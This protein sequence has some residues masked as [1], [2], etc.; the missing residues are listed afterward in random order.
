MLLF[1]AFSCSGIDGSLLKI[2]QVHGADDA[3]TQVHYH[4]RA[5]DGSE[6]LA[7]SLTQGN[8]DTAIDSVSRETAVRL[9]IGVSNEG[10]VTSSSTALQ[11]QYGTKITSCSAVAAWV[12]VNAVNAAWEMYDS[13]H[14]TDGSNTTNISEAAGG[15]TDENT[16]FISA[17]A[18]LKDTS[19]LV[20]STTLASTEF[21]ETEFSIIQ[22]QQAAYGATYCFRLSASGSP[23]DAYSVYPE[24]TTA[25]ERDF[26]V[27][28][29]TVTVSGTSATITAGVDYIAPA[30]TSSAFIRI[31]NS[32]YT[33]AGK[34]VIGGTQPADDVTVAIADPENIAT[35]V[36]FTRA[37]TALNN[38]R[39]SWE[40]VEFVGIPGSDNEF[41]VRD[42]DVL[43]YGTT[44]LSA[45]GTAASVA[46]DNDVVVFIT[47]QRTPDT[48]TSD[49]NTGIS[50]AAWANATDEPV[51]TRGETGGDAAVVSY[52]VVEFTGAN[53]NIERVEH[54][55]AAA[56]VTETESITPVNSLVR[57]F[58]HTQKRSGTGLSGTDEYGHEVWLSSIGAVSFLLQNGA[59]NPGD[60]TSV[61]WVI[62]NTQTGLGSM[63]VT[64]SNG[65]TSGGDEPLTLSVSIG[66]TLTDIS[67]A[68]IFAN[69][70]GVGIGTTYPRPIAGFFIASS[71]HYEIWRSDTGTQMD[72]R[73]E[74]VEWPTAKLSL[75]QNDYRFYVDN[76]AIDPTDPWPEG[77]VDL[78][79]NTVLTETDEP[80]QNGERIRIRMSLTAETA[81]FPQYS[82]SFKLQYGERISTCG[83]ISEAN[84]T[85]V[86]AIGSGALW[87]GYNA[88]TTD[89]TVLSTEPPT[90]GDLNLTV[91][92]TAG[93]YEKENS[94]AINPY[95]VDMGDDVEFD[96]L[97]QQ[98]NAPSGTFYCFRMV[99]QNGTLLGEYTDYPQLR[100]ASFNPRSQHWRFY[101]DAENETP[102]LALASEVTAPIDVTRNDSLKLRVTVKEISNMPED[103]ARF[104]LQFSEDINFAT[105]T[106]VS[107]TSTCTN[108]SVWCYFD[109]AGVDNATITTAVLSDADSCSAGAGVGCGTHNESPL[110][111]SGFRHSNGAATE[112]EFSIIPKTVHVNTVYYFRLYD[113]NADLPVE[114]NSGESYPS[115]VTTGATLVFT[116]EGLPSG[117]T[118]DSY[119]TDA[120]TTP[121]SV[122]F[123]TVPFDTE[124]EAAHRLAVDTNATEGYQVL[125]YSDQQL[126]NAYGSQ[127]EP[128]AGTNAVPLSWDNG[129]AAD[130]DSCFGYHV[131]DD[132]L[133]GVSP[134]RFGS[135]DSFA[136]FSQSPQE[137][138]YSS[139]PASDS[140]DIVYK[141]QVEEN[142]PSGA[143]ETNVTYIA[144]PV[145]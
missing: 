134:A 98:N 12:N 48:T 51:F 27:Q 57:S 105:S 76:N 52:A 23:L 36:T 97:I 55:Y 68:S 113:V 25:S 45:T 6:T 17:N 69:T 103:D 22:T 137:V 44:A 136:A 78:G 9:R 40:I 128:V 125:M 5:D 58:I 75:D 74:V 112:Y 4:W 87:R 28:R 108:T 11:L 71:T 88:S 139:I 84:W 26:T 15:I 133:Q 104:K 70:S 67:V 33:G 142:Q 120:T 10:V 99:E 64:R 1:L 29:G 8:E 107:S 127:I 3:L 118:T 7:A 73:T 53:W 34:N 116:V 121:S 140:H 138:M 114:T 81:T 93:T 42:Q 50:T 111:H 123:G 43:T 61:A 102:S 94:S 145:F 143:Y 83:A 126:L 119:V 35:S 20:A 30:A 19:P 77:V 115:L 117:T 56:G 106:D 63:A 39:V 135:D 82:K 14:I 41:I 37:G 46:D 85:D 95:A 90:S 47:G 49:Y 24:L 32:H 18:A 59:N 54:T 13:S 122:A 109:G 96:W 62:E 100:T 130:A 141:I 60:Q 110:P 131:G 2:M 89:G 16:T 129:C 80:L 144:V 86:G 92:D 124:F 72:Y 66:K 91:S 38:S 79:E 21:I 132:S 101:G 31:T 65:N